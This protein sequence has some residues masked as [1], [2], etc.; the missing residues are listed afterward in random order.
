MRAW[1]LVTAMTGA[2]ATHAAAE[3]LL[4]AG[5]DDGKRQ[6]WYLTSGGVAAVAKDP[7]LGSGDALSLATLGGASQRRVLAHF[8]AVELARPGDA[9]VLR[10]DYR[11]T[12]SADANRGTGDAEGGFRF[13]LF[14]SRGT[15]QTADATVQASS[16][17]ASDDVGYLAMTSVGVRN[18]ARLVQ[19]K[20]EDQHFMGGPDLQFHHTED[21]FGGTNDSLKHSAVFT[22]RRATATTLALE[23][24]VDGKKAIRAEIEDPATTR[25]DVVG[26]ASSHRASD[27]T[28][29][30]VEVTSETAST[31]SAKGGSAVRARCEPCTIE[32]GK[33]TTLTVEAGGVVGRNVTYKWSAST[34]KFA[35]PTARQ[36]AW[37]APLRKGWS[38]ERWKGGGGVPIT[39]TVD[40]GAGGTATA[41]VTVDVTRP[42]AR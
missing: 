40:D 12:G 19:E 9:V 29:D 8:K 18:R 33:V 1:T 5:F 20:A 7:T 25:F 34:G 13:G 41:T 42:A 31:T 39:V 30:N 2:L 17:S 32:I 38:E 3:S 23:A 21:D 15:L 26:F 27:F 36:T 4:K 35:D 22:I 10:F 14:D 11:I 24:V 6:G 16:A 28:I 37:T